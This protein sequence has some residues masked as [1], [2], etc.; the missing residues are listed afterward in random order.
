MLALKGLL[1]SVGTLILLMVV[2]L[3]VVGIIKLIYR[4]ISKGQSQKAATK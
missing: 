4:V 1:F 3:V 2:S